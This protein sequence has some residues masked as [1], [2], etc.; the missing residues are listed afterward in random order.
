MYCFQM[1]MQPVISNNEKASD[2]I[3]CDRQVGELK[4]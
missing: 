2:L 3:V 4:E 1:V